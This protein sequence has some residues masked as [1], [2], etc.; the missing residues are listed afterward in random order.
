MKHVITR[1]TLTGSG[2]MLGLIGSALVFNPI[3][4]LEVNSV[5]VARDP[6]LMSELAAPSGVLIASG[7]LMLFGAIK[8]RFATLSLLVG[9]VVYGSYG[10][11]RVIG[12]FVHGLPPESLMMA[13]II[14]FA[15]AALLYGLA[16][17]NRFGPNAADTGVQI[18]QTSP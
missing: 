13:T 10:I 6:G 11:G 8:I 2:T 18:L 5:F 17:T 12:M 1:L 7:A 16:F 4:F 9:A 14:E 3:S 15:V